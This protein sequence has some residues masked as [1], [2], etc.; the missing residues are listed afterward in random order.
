[1]TRIDTTLLVLLLLLLSLCTPFS[2]S[3]LT[4][5]F[6]L[7]QRTGEAVLEGSLQRHFIQVAADKYHLVD[8]LLI[9][10][11]SSLRRLA[12]DLL[13]YPLEHEFRIPFPLERQHPFTAV[14]VTRA[15]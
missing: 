4:I 5:I 10:L 12:H 1:M 14:Q 9:R 15:F 8:T 7:C 2:Y 13:M 6:I 3:V 11:P